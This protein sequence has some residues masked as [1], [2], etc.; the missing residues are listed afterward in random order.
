MR[1]IIASGGVIAA[2]ALVPAAL[3]G[4]GTPINR[5]SANVL[6]MAVYGDAPYGTTPTDTAQFQAMP[7]FIGS[8]NQDPK[9]RQVLHIGDIHSGKQYCTEAYDRSI[10]DLFAGFKDPLVYTPGDNE[11][12]DCH[13][14]AEGG[15]MY[16][17]M[18]RQIDYVRDANGN[19][20]DYAGGDP[21]ANLALVRSTF[22]PV[23]GETL[24][25]RRKRVISQADAYDPAYPSD[26]A[27][28]ENVMWEQSKVLFVT[29]NIPGGSNNDND[30]WYGEPS[31]SARQSREVAERTG[32]DLR[33]IDAAFAQA[34]ADGVE[35]VLIGSQADMWDNEKGPAHQAGYEPFVSSLASHTTDFGKPVLLLNGDSHEYLSDNPLS[36]SNAVH[37]GYDV[38]NFHRIVVHGSKFPLEWLRL[39]ID[40][41]TS[42]AA[43]AQ[44]FGPFSWERVQP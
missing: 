26:A 42:D 40:P 39:T 10:F 22:F 34:R 14:K 29:V 35:A 8:I 21:L 3:A 20:V 43:T 11:W 33:W 16:N 12:T 25:G 38:P 28:V 30:V 6:T 9:V 17:P 36:P 1:R 23:A 5:G 31:M 13:K 15:G 37:P 2:L 41:R 19:L 44:A 32:A 4:N 18:T 24:G 27:F 7:G